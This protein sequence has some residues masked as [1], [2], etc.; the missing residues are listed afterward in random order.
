MATTLE[1]Q[2]KDAPAFET[3]T[4]RATVFHGGNPRAIRHPTRNRSRMKGDR[5][6]HETDSNGGLATNT[7]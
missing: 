2:K 7:R 5:D 3:R 1:H 6:A 4:M